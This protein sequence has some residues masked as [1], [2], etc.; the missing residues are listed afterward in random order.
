MKY[1]VIRTI[2][3][4]C[5]KFVK[6]SKLLINKYFFRV[7]K[8]ELFLKLKRIGLKKGSL[9]YVHTAMS[10]FGYVKGGPDIVLDSIL[11]LIGNKGTV[12]M[13][14]FTHLRKKFSLNDPCWTGKV[15]ETLRLRN[16]SVRSVHP[17]HSV[18]A[19]GPLAKE[20]TDGHEKSRAPFD[21]K[22]PFHKLAKKKSYILMLGT[23]NNSMI[24]YV[25]DKVNFPNL[26]VEKIHQFKYKNKLIST[27]LHHPDGSIKYI[28][29]GRPCSDV[30]FLIDF[31]RNEKFEDKEFMK[32]V[33]IGKA[34][35]HLINTQD[36]V[37]EATKYLQ[38]NIKRYKKEYS[39]LIKN[40]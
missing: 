3:R 37:R 2:Y 31:Y 13:P 22:S 20:I 23:E 32:T 33:R 34:V 8:K 7:T 27:K 17:T 4:I 12:V 21:E 30:K 5:R 1:S 35:C 11:R 15:S 40:G 36:F 38:N 16:D 28:C 14:A 29:G 6:K 18:V 19:F 39:T 24:H 26:F 25:Q 9:V 10:S